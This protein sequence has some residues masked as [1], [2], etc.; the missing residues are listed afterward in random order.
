MR[1]IEY[2]FNEETK[3]GYV[4]KEFPFCYSEEKEPLCTLVV[5]NSREHAELLLSTE[6]WY[7][8]NTD[9][10]IELELITRSNI[11]KETEE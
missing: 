3:V 4:V 9:D 7:S 10:H 2:R 1:K 8:I 5:C 11:I 6:D